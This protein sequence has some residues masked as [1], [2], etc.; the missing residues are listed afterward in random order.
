MWEAIA[1]DFCTVRRGSH[2]LVQ[3]SSIYARRERA[4]VR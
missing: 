4:F 2:M 1:V 3:K